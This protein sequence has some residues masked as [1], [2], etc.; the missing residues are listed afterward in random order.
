MKGEMVMLILELCAFILLALSLFLEEKER[1]EDIARLSVELEVVHENLSGV[2]QEIR[3]CERLL[4]D[5]GGGIADEVSNN[6]VNGSD[7]FA[8]GSGPCV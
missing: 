8:S 7:G 5:S 3:F 2:F 1:K 6:V 4:K